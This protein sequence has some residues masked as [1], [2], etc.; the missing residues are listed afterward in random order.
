MPLFQPS[1]IT[2][3][4]FAGVG[5]GTVAVADNVKITWQVNG[6]TPLTGFKIDIYDTDN[7]SVYSSGEIS[8]SPFY[9]VDNKGNPQYYSYVPNT[10]WAELGL[11]DGK[12]YTLQITQYW[13][14]KTDEAHSTT[15]FSQSSFITRTA[16]TLIISTESGNTDFSTVN[17]VFQG[18]KAIYS[19]EQEDSIDWVRWQFYQGDFLIEDT[20]LVNTQ[21]LLYTANNMQSGND[22]TVI[23]T[24][25]TERGVE[26]ST[27]KSFSVAYE[28]PIIEGEFSVNCFNKASNLLKW[29]EIHENIGDDIQ[30]VSN[31]DNYSFQ[32][33]SLVLP[34]DSTATWNTKNEEELHIS[35]DWSL[36]WKGRVDI[37]KKYETKGYF[38][39]LPE[40]YSVRGICF[41]SDETKMLVY[42]G[43]LGG[44]YIGYIY[45]ISIDKPRVVGY[46]GDVLVNGKLTDCVTAT[47]IKS[48]YRAEEV[49]FYS[50]GTSYGFIGEETVNTYK[51][52]I[53][54]CY[55]KSN[56][57]YVGCDNGVAVYSIDTNEVSVFSYIDTAIN[58]QGFTHI[59]T[60]QKEYLLVFTT[61]EV[62][63]YDENLISDS[64]ELVKSIP[65]GENLGKTVFIKDRCLVAGSYVFSF[66][67]YLNFNII[68]QIDDSLSVGI[69]NDG[70]FFSAKPSAREVYIY[71]LYNGNIVG[72][73]S[74]EVGGS[75]KPV[76]AT[77]T[78]SKFL[79]FAYGLSGAQVQFWSKKDKDSTPF[80]G[81]EKLSVIA[82][83]T[84]LIQNK[85]FAREFDFDVSNELVLSLLNEY[86]VEFLVQVNSTEVSI[87]YNGEVK[88]EIIDSAI[89]PQEAITSIVLSGEQVCDYLYISRGTEKFDE[90]FNPTWIE[91][92]AFLTNFDLSTLQAG[93]L[94]VAKNAMDIY[95]ENLSNET[96]QKL[97]SLGVGITQ[98]RDFSW[99]TGNKYK[100]YGYARLDN[101]YTSANPFMELPIC[102]V[103]PYY[104]LLATTQDENEPNVYH[105]VHYW[106][107]G[108]NIE[109]G[110]VSNNNT[111]NFLNNFTGYRLKQPTARKG[112][113][114]VLTALLSNA[115]ECEYKDT[116]RQMDNLYALSECKNTLFLKDMKGNL[117][118]VAISGAITQTINNKSAA[119]EVRV[120]IPWEEVGSAEDVSIIQLPTD[121]GWVDD[122]AQLDEVRLEVDEETGMLKVIYP[123]GYNYATTF[124]IESP[125]LYTSTKDGVDQ[126]NVELVDGAVIL[127]EEK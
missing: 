102:R 115:T 107:F 77:T 9:P 96:F 30:G 120:S 93:Q 27:E 82:T 114:G 110:S 57:L 63:V 22:Y 89:Y 52:N 122:N 106:R 46:L 48:P 66:D 42:G 56:R 83:N 34:K 6:N 43:G 73:G 117:Y 61:S 35:T 116:V 17:S 76:A 123:T 13:G 69:T 99:I 98:M 10:T 51:G 21:V 2:P 62:L 105:V 109:A 87:Y 70:Y 71:R 91:N 94:E 74:Y 58:V 19:Q 59:A 39:S 126:A 31:D 79:V 12:E 8:I 16:P 36:A 97:Y 108:N 127:N 64:Y 33:G 111:P 49:I 118:M 40:Y 60:S 32:N 113:N 103:Q 80:L 1:N 119:H 65:T 95:R 26:V 104:L 20:G 23:C 124:G 54:S 125:N 75:V 28:L 72:I 84:L 90:Y 37:A 7:N 88:T 101:K 55:A 38:D 68:G 81:T 18:F 5:G 45:D 29:S 3:S 25:Q 41:N 92:T 67:D 47:Y 14:G 53:R 11:T 112:K 85:N 50:F 44:S 78:N 100:Y 121:E 86:I 15:Q 4:S 24:I